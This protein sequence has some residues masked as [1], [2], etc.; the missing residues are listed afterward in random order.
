MP[1]GEMRESFLAGDLA[2]RA[3]S[4]DGKSQ[5][6]L[7]LVLHPGEIKQLEVAWEFL[8]TQNN[9][10]LGAGVVLE[11]LRSLDLDF[12]HRKAATRLLQKNAGNFFKRVQE[13]G[14][15][16]QLDPYYLSSN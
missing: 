9:A 6:E 8:Q 3:R 14:R 12:N 11:Y 15:R 2:D 13:Y 16:K 10:Q 7:I 5:G 4:A 1:N